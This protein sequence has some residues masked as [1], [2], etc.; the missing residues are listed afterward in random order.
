MSYNIEA[1]LHVLQTGGERVTSPYGHRTIYI[2]GAYNSNFHGGIDLINRATGTGYIVAAARGVVTATRN[3]ISGY[4]ESYASGNYVKLEHANGYATEYLHMAKGTVCVA[5]GQTVEKGQVLG[6][7]GTTGWSTGNHLHF[8]VR[9]NG[10]T[11]DPEPNLLGAK[12]IP[13][14]GGGTTNLSESKI[15]LT[16]A[17]LYVSST[18][19]T[20]SGR[21]TGTYYIWSATQI[22]GRY[23]VTNAADNIGMTGQV[24]GWVNTS[25]IPATEAELQPTPNADHAACNT[26]ITTLEDQLRAVK[27]IVAN[28]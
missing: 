19:T 7:M 20:P 16:N 1:R 25:D 24:T 3:T 17:P 21:L 8:G 12:S 6:Y 2:N 13:G 10:S 18:A 14:Y 27:E 26:K 11:V 4:S 23:R 15:T 9:I 22:N 28:L 5:V